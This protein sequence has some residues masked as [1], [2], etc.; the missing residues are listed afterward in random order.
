WE[1]ERQEDWSRLWDKRKA[2]AFRRWF[3]D[4]V[5]ELCGQDVNDQVLEYF[6]D[7]STDEVLLMFQWGLPG[8]EENMTYYASRAASLTLRQDWEEEFHFKNEKND[9]TMPAIH[10][11]PFPEEDCE[12]FLWGP[13][14]R[15]KFYALEK[16][17]NVHEFIRRDA[18][19]PNYIV[20]RV[21]NL[22]ATQAFFDD[23]WRGTMIEVVQHDIVN[24]Y[25]PIHPDH[26]PG[27]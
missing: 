1:L 6:D 22:E 27:F 4:E 11:A 5:E 19:S 25:D 13:F 8:V 17:I 23:F 3:A 20:S 7:F 16:A 21:H 26:N 14:F 2:A 9:Q 12:A 10:C 24:M 18:N 15:K